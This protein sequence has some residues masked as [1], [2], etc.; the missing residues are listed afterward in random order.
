MKTMY[1]MYI[2]KN[3]SGCYFG[4]VPAKS[5]RSARTKFLNSFSGQFIIEGTDGSFMRVN[6]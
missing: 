2:L 1:Y 6:L 5:I 3:E 4:R